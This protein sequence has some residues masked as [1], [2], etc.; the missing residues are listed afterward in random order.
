MQIAEKKIGDM[1]HDLT[2]KYQMQ[3]QVAITEEILDITS[4]FEVL[5]EEDAS[6][7]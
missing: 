6:N 7:F 4:S 2:K 5:R 3:R 1:I